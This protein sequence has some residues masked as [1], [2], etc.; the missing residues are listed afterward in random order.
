MNPICTHLNSVKDVTPG[1]VGCEECLKS[2]DRWV[3]LRLCT[4]CGHV[5]CCDES[6]NRHAT[7]HF[8][9]TGHPI[10]RSFEQ[11]EDWMWCYVDQV[12]IYP[13][14]QGERDDEQPVEVQMAE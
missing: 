2:G 8:H 11:G 13:S 14:V 5:G 9:S 4:V 12:L 3:H 7:G 1:S 6:K 10:I